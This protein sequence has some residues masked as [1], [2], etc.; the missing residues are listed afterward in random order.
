[1]CF[2][3]A[4]CT[5]IQRYTAL[6]GAR[7]S[8]VQCRSGDVAIVHGQWCDRAECVVKGVLRCCCC[9]WGIFEDGEEWEDGPLRQQM[10][11]G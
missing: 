10:V 4:I 9:H 2:L 6:L 11:V 5:A 8:E 1:M 3:T 7:L